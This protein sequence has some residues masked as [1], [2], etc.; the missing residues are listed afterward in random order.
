MAKVYH[1]NNDHFRYRDGVFPEDYDLVAITPGADLGRA[2]ELTNS[3]VRAW[4]D[5]PSVVAFDP[6]TRST[7][8]GDVVVNDEGAHLCE[9]FGWKKLEVDPPPIPEKTLRLWRE[10]VE[11]RR[12]GEELRIA[13]ERR[14]ELL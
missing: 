14:K 12:I 3:V 8:V 1:V 10:I 5:N 11:E 4:T 13:E 6:P 7:S 2:F 9:P